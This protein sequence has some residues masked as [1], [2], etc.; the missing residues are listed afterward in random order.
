MKGMSCKRIFK[1][2]AEDFYPI[3]LAQC[4]KLLNLE[5]NQKRDVEINFKC[6]S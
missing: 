2:W 1:N 5:G 4:Q 6:I 3:V